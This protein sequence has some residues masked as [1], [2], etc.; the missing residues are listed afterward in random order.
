MKVFLSLNSSSLLKWLT[1]RWKVQKFFLIKIA[2][3]C[4]SFIPRIFVIIFLVFSWMNSQTSET[5][6]YESTQFSHH[7]FINW[8]EKSLDLAKFHKNVRLTFKYI[9]L[10]QPWQ[11]FVKLCK[12]KFPKNR[13]K[14]NFIEV[15]PIWN[16]DDA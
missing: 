14:K 9:Q 11:I 10:I 16:F 12:K 15:L 13:I 1:M 5:W 6:F 8:L 3:L 4:F 2:K 7:S